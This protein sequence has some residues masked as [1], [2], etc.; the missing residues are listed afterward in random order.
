MSTATASSQTAQKPGTAKRIAF[1]GLAAAIICVLGPLSIPLP[2]SPVPISL[3]IFA[4]YIAVYAL[5]MKWGTVACIV[6]ILLGLVGLPVFSGFTGGAAKLLGPTGG[7]IIGFL[8]VALLSGLFIDKFKNRPMSI[9]GMVLGTAVCYFFGT[10]W[11]A[12]QAGMTFE[13][14]LWAGV[15]PFIPADAVKI[16]IA[17]LVGPQLRKALRLAH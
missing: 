12:Y 14:A 3:T 13:A 1:I 15:I 8:F 9:V 4:V 5:G 17:I 7:Y 11:L 2:F 16:V 6:Y 10:V